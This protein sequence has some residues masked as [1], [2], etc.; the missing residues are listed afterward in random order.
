MLQALAQVAAAGV[1][2]EADLVGVDTLEGEAVRLAHKLGLSSQVRFLGFK[3]QREL[4]PLVEAADLLLMSSLH[5]AGPLVLLEA[6]VAGVPAVGT[7]VGHFV[8]WS[9]SACVAVPVRDAAALAAA[10]C[11]VLDDDALRLRLAASAQQRALAEDAGTTLR[12]FE[13]LYRRACA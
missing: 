6:A 2:F 13:D 8:E 5:E 12:C 10:V 7:A 3:T 11:R 1:A 9:P 4:R